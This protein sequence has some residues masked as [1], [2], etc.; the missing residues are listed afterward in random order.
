VRGEGML[1]FSMS[2][3]RYVRKPAAAFP[4][5]TS[6]V[7]EPPYTKSVP[8]SKPRARTYFR[9]GALTTL[10]VVW[11][12]VVCA[13]SG[14]QAASRSTG[15]AGGESRFAIADFDGDSRPDLATV[16]VGLSGT[17]N[18]RYWIDFEMSAG[19]RQ[20]IGVMAPAGGL[21]IAPRDVN[22]DQSL[23][24]V[25]TTAW[26][27]RP[28]AVL[29]N[30]GHGNFTY[31]DA[32]AFGG[33][34]WSFDTRWFGVKVDGTDA[35]AWTRSDGAAQASV[36]LLAVRRQSRQTYSRPRLAAARSSYLVVPGRAPPASSLSA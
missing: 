26:L 14:G 32:K 6:D 4:A 29:L 5:G 20:L 36:N 24:L 7:H 31:R 15:M 34:T 3:K 11:G 17:S 16:Q 25:V 2:A 28:V 9:W 19:S 12:L 8:M 21:Q 27:D 10:L 22:G 13:A 33:M 1:C 35:V 23:D 30:D 18:A